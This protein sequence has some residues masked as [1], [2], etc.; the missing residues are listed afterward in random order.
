MAHILYCATG[1]LNGVTQL[2]L[3]QEPALISGDLHQTEVAQEWQKA[4]TAMIPFKTM[5]KSLEEEGIQSPYAPDGDKEFLQWG[6]ERTNVAVENSRGRKK[7]KDP[8]WKPEPR[9][10]VK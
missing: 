5:D 8:K 10:K 3:H 1:T 7:K 2:M 6:T 9:Y 4:P